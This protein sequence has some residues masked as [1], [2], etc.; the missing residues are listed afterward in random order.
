MRSAILIAWCA[1]TIPT[2][3]REIWGQHSLRQ[4]ITASNV[5]NFV[6]RGL[7]SI[8][9]TYDEGQMLAVY[10][11]PLYPY[12]VAAWSMA[13]GAGVVVVGRTFSALAMV[14]GWLAL[15]RLLARGGASE[16]L[17]TSTLAL[18]CAA[19]LGIFYGVGVFSD[20]L[21]V[22]LSL[23]SLAAWAGWETDGRRE[24]RSSRFATFVGAGALCA[25]VKSPIYL[26]VAVAIGVH[27]IVARGPR[28]L[29]RPWFVGWSA[30][31]VGSIAASQV[32]SNH[33]NRNS[34][35]WSESSA[36]LDWYFADVDQRLDPARWQT[37]LDV[38]GSQILSPFTVPLAVLGLVL[39][40][41]RPSPWSTLTLGWAGGVLVTVFVFFG[42]HW[43]H[44]YYQLPFVAPLALVAA[45]GARA[46]LAAI[47]RQSVLAAFAAGA[48][49]VG[50]AWTTME[51]VMFLRHDWQSHLREAGRFVALHT[52]PDD[53]V[54][55]LVEPGQVATHELYCAKRYGRGVSTLDFRPAV[56]RQVLDGLSRAPGYRAYGRF[57]VFVPRD[58]QDP[59]WSLD[60][61]WELVATDGVGDLWLWSG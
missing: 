10:E 50:T 19:P 36:E 13:T 25:L 23:V 3:T 42:L 43:R 5:E 38:L 40:V 59:T 24:L 26:P 2:L 35:G 15:D 48:M 34:P 53:Y 7:F 55:L 51:G 44:S 45:H 1:A 4:V 18:C 22:G 37:V 17:R 11:F 61:G 21:C 46:F 20:P 49:V 30:A 8:P 27:V 47:A 54:F 9:R 16:P 41:S 39:L 28:E 29:I 14:V 32:V 57:V 33:L 31:L 60:D 52:A 12:L 58:L 56:A 6:A